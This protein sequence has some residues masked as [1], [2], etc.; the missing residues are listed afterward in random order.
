MRGRRGQ[1]V[2]DSILKRLRLSRL[3]FVPFSRFF[4]F[5]EDKVMRILWWATC[6]V[7]SSPALVGLVTAAIV[8]AKVKSREHKCQHFVRIMIVCSVFSSNNDSMMES[9]VQ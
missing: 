3:D 7:S 5:R 6:W 1:T 4:T 9:S 2:V 8:S